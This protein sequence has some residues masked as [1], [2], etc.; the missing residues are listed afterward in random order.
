MFVLLFAFQCDVALDVVERSLE[1]VRAAAGHG[2]HLQA[3]RAAVLG[4]I[5]R[6][7]DADFLNRFDADAR[8]RTIDAGIH[9]RRAV[10][11]E[12]AVTAAA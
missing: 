7:R 6:R 8:G 5:R 12:V 2:V 9:R 3:A 1:A 10:D 11:H 4:L